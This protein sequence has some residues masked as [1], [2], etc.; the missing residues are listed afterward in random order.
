[1]DILAST[2]GQ[3]RIALPDLRKRVHNQLDIQIISEYKK[4]Y[5]TYKVVPF[6]KKNMSTYTRYTPELVGEIIDKLFG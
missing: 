3:W 5:N 1:M 6:S 2:K 4:F